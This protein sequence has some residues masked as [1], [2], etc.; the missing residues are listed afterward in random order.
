M[1]NEDNKTEEVKSVE[2]TVTAATK[3]PAKKTSKPKAATKQPA[4]PAVRRSSTPVA[5]ETTA[6]QKEAS[7]VVKKQTP[8]E[9]IWT[10]IKERDLGLFGLKNQLVQKY[11]TPLELDPSK[12]FVKYKVSS[13]IPAL[14]SAA[15][16]YNFE[17][18]T[19]Y[20]VLSKK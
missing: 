18:V 12:C 11:C 20:I 8:S 9:E 19:D 14:E 7:P 4:A 17:V 6:S 13:V 10:A 16:E 1:K 5:K 2:P 15:Q 3:T